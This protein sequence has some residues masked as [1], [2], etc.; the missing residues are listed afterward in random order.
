VDFVLVALLGL[1]YARRARRLGG[2]VPWPRQASFYTGLAVLLVALGLPYED[3]LFA[4]HML[5]HV[6]L[7]DLAPL[8]IVA[9]LTGPMLRPVLALP[10]VE[11]LRALAHPVRR[12]LVAACL[13]AP[14]PAGELVELTA[15]APASV[16]EHLKVLR[17]TGLLVLEARGRFRLYSTDERVVRE[18][19][20]GVLECLR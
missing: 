16:S 20:E 4:M 8:A 17:K 6:L 19:A 13:A 10:A 3:R 11:R 18:T 2:R 14:R 12:E 1:L 15:L 9:G 7:G 5:Q